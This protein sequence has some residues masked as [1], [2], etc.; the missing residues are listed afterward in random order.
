MEIA[1]FTKI[2][3][4]YHVTGQRSDSIERS[5]L[6]TIAQKQTVGPGLTV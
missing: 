5:V 1:K 6:Q 2:K 4:W 3:H